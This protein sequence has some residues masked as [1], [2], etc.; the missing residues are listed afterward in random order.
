LLNLFTFFVAPF[1]TTIPATLFRRQLDHFLD[2]E[3]E[4]GGSSNDF[5][6]WFLEVLEREKGERENSEEKE[7][8]NKKAADERQDTA[9]LERAKAEINIQKEKAEKKKG[10]ED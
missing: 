8:G 5:G 9:E 2:P 10:I 4:G 7:P 1:T 6:R 3:Q